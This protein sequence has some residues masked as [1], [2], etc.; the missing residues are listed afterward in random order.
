MRSLSGTEWGASKACLLTMYKALIRSLLDYG[1]IAL[2][3]AIDS[4][5]S[6]FDQVQAT[7]LKI[8]CGSAR[9]T[10]LSALQNE[11]GELPL[12]L[13]R[14]RQQLRYAIK[15]K[16]TENHPSSQVLSDHWTNHYGKCNENR[17]SIYSNT[18]TFF[19]RY[20]LEINKSKVTQEPPWHV[21]S[22]VID[23]SLSRVLKKTDPPIQIKAIALERIA[24][25]SEYLVIY[26]DGSK[27]PTGQ[28]SSAFS[29]PELKVQHRVRITDNLSVYTAELI[30]IKQSLEWIAT[31]ERDSLI[32]DNRNVV[33]F[34]DSLS[35]VQSLDSHSSH[36]R[37][38]LVSEILLVKKQLAHRSVTVTW[39]PG[40]SGIKGNDEADLLAKE[41]LVSTVVNLSV[42][43][44]VSDH[45]DVIEKYIVGLW[46]DRW[47]KSTTGTFNRSIT[48]MVSTKSKFNCSSRSKERLIS[49][50]RLG[51]CLLNQWLFQMKLHD[52]GFCDTCMAP[53]TIEHFL[54]DCKES[55]LVRRLC[56]QAG[57]QPGQ[58]TLQEILSDESLHTVLRGNITRKL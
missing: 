49:R 20:T 53:E 11:C 48:P 55:D 4:A 52:N 27:N 31:A 57:K 6:R 22:L 32:D 5:K 50:L 28:V 16:S 42:Y 26:T 41:A 1:A 19:D 34:T 14:H 35:S 7:A 47:N 12:D 10:A 30:A 18:R 15:V 9:G 40:H 39:I 38:N 54:L 36:S 23:K 24:C 8:C 29:V 45:Y 33:I 13:S 43:H 37:P 44:E 51:K 46:Q 17:M 25:Y 58:L 2:E 56:R 3:T 21:E